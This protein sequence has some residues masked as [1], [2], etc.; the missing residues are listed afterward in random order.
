MENGEVIHI[1]KGS[2][3]ELSKGW[4]KENAPL[5]FFE[6]GDGFEVDVTKYDPILTEN[7]F[8]RIKNRLETIEKN[9]NQFPQDLTYATFNAFCEATVCLHYMVLRLKFVK[10]KL[11]EVMRE[12]N[13]ARE[14]IIKA[15][16]CHWLKKHSFDLC[17][18]F[19]GLVPIKFRLSDVESTLL[20]AKIRFEL[21]G[22]CFT[23]ARVSPSEARNDFKKIEY[24]LVDVQEYMLQKI[25]TIKKEIQKLRQIGSSQKKQLN[26]KA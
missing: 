7:R 17:M 11:E 6:T 10:K 9:I 15:R 14:I 23:C 8:E 26:E 1:E 25:E 21:E 18:A 12:F 19:S 16:N 4:F 13:E 20:T 24:L 2:T 22:R 5:E 3:V